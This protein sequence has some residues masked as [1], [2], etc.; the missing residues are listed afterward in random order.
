MADLKVDLLN[1]LRNDKYFA[2]IELGRLAADPT[3]N[4]KEKIELMDGKLAEIAL[5]NS[6]MAL[7]EQYFQDPNQQQQ[8]QMPPMQGGAPVQQQ[9]QGHVHPGQTHGE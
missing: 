8:V 7:A 4:Y 2:E 1:K 6:E 3:M 9:P 5:L